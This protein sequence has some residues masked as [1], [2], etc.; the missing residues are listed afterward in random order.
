MSQ[1]NGLLILGDHLFLN[2]KKHG[3]RGLIN[4]AGIINPNLTL[5]IYI[6][7][8]IK[9]YIYTLNNLLNATAVAAPQGMT[10]SLEAKELVYDR[11]DEP[12]RRSGTWCEKNTGFYQDKLRKKNMD[13]TE[14]TGKSCEV[15]S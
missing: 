7:Y 9:T 4:T 2:Y 1:P 14:I 5:R 6:L 11:E 15:E 3:Q 8:Y 10:R 12:A 13:F